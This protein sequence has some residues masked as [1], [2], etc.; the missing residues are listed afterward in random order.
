MAIGYAVQRA[1]HRVGKQIHHAVRTVAHTAKQVYDAAP[2]ADKAIY[3][4]AVPLYGKVVRP[5]LH[6]QGVDTRHIDHGLMRGL[7][8]YE[9]VRSALGR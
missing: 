5:I 3:N 8:T 7:K 1:A 4:Y 2:A 9:S 6:S